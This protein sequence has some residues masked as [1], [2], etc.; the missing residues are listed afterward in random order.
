MF[1]FKYLVYNKSMNEITGSLE[2]GKFAERLLEE[3]GLNVLEDEVVAQL[4]ADLVDR[5][6]NRVNAVILNALPKDLMGDFEKLLDSEAGDG[7]VQ[8]FCS[9]HISGLDELIAA[10]LVAFRRTYIGA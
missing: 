3:K 7:A 8:E 4:K 6:E 5:L 9:K 2:L 10:E 1:F